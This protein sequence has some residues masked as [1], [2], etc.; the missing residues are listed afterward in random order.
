MLGSPFDHT[1]DSVVREGD[2][3]RTLSAPEQVRY[4]NKQAVLKRRA[5]AYRREKRSS[6][7]QSTA[8]NTTHQQLNTSAPPKFALGDNAPRHGTANHSASPPVSFTDSPSVAERLGIDMTSVDA[9]WGSITK[10]T[11]L[12]SKDVPVAYG[13]VLSVNV[14]NSLAL[15]SV[16]REG[17]TTYTHVK[18]PLKMFPLH[19]LMKLSPQE[20]NAA[21][22]KKV[23]SR[24][25][26]E[27]RMRQDGVE[28]GAPFA[29][30]T[31]NNRV[32]GDLL[33]SAL[34]EEEDE[35]WE[36]KRVSGVLEALG[37]VT[38][39]NSTTSTTGSNAHVSNSVYNTRDTADALTQVALLTNGGTSGNPA[40]T[41][42]YS[43]LSTR[44]GRGG[45]RA[46]SQQHRPGSSSIKVSILDDDAPPRPLRMRDIRKPPPRGP[47][48]LLRE[49]LPV[50]RPILD[51]F[52]HIRRSAPEFANAGMKIKTQLDLPYSGSDDSDGPGLGCSIGADPNAGDAG[53]NHNNT[54]SHQQELE[55]Q[56][57]S[58]GE[59]RNNGS[60]RLF[61]LVGSTQQ[62]D[63]TS[64]N[65]SPRPKDTGLL[66]TGRSAISGGSFFG[67]SASAQDEVS[68]P[69][70]SRRQN[71]P[72]TGMGG[73]TT[74]SSP[75]SQSVS[76]GHTPRGVNEGGPII[77]VLASSASQL[78][79]DPLSATATSVAGGGSWAMAGGGRGVFSAIQEARSGANSAIQGQLARGREGSPRKEGNASS[80][81]PDANHRHS[82]TLEGSIL[83]NFGASSLA[84][85]ASSRMQL[86][87]P[88]SAARQLV[89]GALGTFTPQRPRNTISTP[90]SSSHKFAVTAQFAGGF[91]ASVSAPPSVHG[92]PVADSDFG[93]RFSDASSS[94]SSSA[95]SPKSGSLSNMLLHPHYVH[96]VPTT[97]KLKGASTN[98]HTEGVRCML[99]TVDI[100]SD[101]KDCHFR[102]QPVA[103][104]REEAVGG[105]G[106]II[107]D[108]YVPFEA[109]LAFVQLWDPPAPTPA[110]IAV[111]AHPHAVTATKSSLPPVTPPAGA[112]T[113]EASMRRRK[114]SLLETPREVSSA[115]ADSLPGVRRVFSMD[116]ST[117]QH[118]GQQQQVA[119]P[120]TASR[121][122]SILRQEPHA[123][124]ERILSPTST[125]GKRAAHTEV[126]RNT[127]ENAATLVLN[128][129]LRHP[130]LGTV[131]V[132][133]VRPAARRDDG[134]FG[135]GGI[136]DEDKPDHVGVQTSN[137]SSSRL[138]SDIHHP[139]EE[140]SNLYNN[141]SS[142]V[143]C[144]GG[145]GEGSLNGPLPPQ[146]LGRRRT[147]APADNDNER[148]D[149]ESLITLLQVDDEDDVE[150]S[151]S[152]RIVTSGGATP[153]EIESGAVRSLSVHSLHGLGFTNSDTI[154]TT[155][156]NNNTS[157]T[158][159]RIIQEQLVSEGLAWVRLPTALLTRVIKHLPED[160]A[161]GESTAAFNRSST[162]LSRSNT[163]MGNQRT[164]MM[165]GASRSA[166]PVTNPISLM[167]RGAKAAAALKALRDTTVE[168]TSLGSRSKMKHRHGAGGGDRL[169]SEEE[170]LWGEYGDLLVRLLVRQREAQ[171]E[172][173][174]MWSYIQN[175]LT[176]M[177]GGVPGAAFGGPILNLSHVL[178]SIPAAKT[179]HDDNS[180]RP[181]SGNQRRSQQP[182]QTINPAS[183][184]RYASSFR[185]AFPGEEED[186]QPSAAMQQLFRTSAGG[187]LDVLFG[188]QTG[189]PEGMAM[190][191]LFAI[192]EA[193]LQ[194]S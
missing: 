22:K 127:N 10:G 183:S 41:S 75:R 11:W 55:R 170:F 147:A 114:V 113:M 27:L 187:A 96:T 109:S 74:P 68:L 30:T 46:G 145:F 7:S 69:A 171:R 191:Q 1:C 79:I 28:V 161:L 174:G 25:Q 193:V 194:M 142:D 192:W 136:D 56:S 95:T 131:E 32:V 93:D 158:T 39:G 92:T 47:G 189:I 169:S 148:S 116:S 63:V 33:D 126:P 115:Q 78:A 138:G 108:S 2:Y 85:E 6:S 38:E 24:L 105:V 14:L 159:P 80:L 107:L 186:V 153:R 86:S 23:V 157:S 17:D 21:C 181:I 91:G 50:V 73:A 61:S 188:N 111:A 62:L 58:K 163:I 9:C 13:T 82:S 51:P 42:S 36:T 48:A 143:G 100:Q 60:F 144:G 185:G 152:M 102:V 90:H 134:P 121:I 141:K 180:P 94:A 89:V 104:G 123:S 167:G 31:F 154:T 137:P 19:T 103:S 15:V 176:S 8:G 146:S 97:P 71:Q 178:L 119:S 57:P 166:M 128:T 5:E 52:R 125:P 77:G 173:K 184:F 84:G 18:K 29:L 190:D 37:R 101:G 34:V 64:K 124:I 135:G 132:V 3:V 72:H 118:R 99:G 44:R 49:P 106:S 43:Q 168:D 175:S 120:S 172:R 98:T 87:V 182:A 40:N 122:R 133:L 70:T 110:P 156:N 45:P 177:L 179:K 165:F 139:S 54:G 67:A 4:D 53:A 112:V 160:P 81:F 155:N 59:H 130:T 35:K 162:W 164:S 20:F 65:A 140:S 151:I 26:Q 66:P 83:I 16:W 117:T 129:G 12:G 150:R 76:P 149:D 88:V